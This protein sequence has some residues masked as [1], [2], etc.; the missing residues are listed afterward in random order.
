MTKVIS[1]DKILTTSQKEEIRKDYIENKMSLREIGDKYKI[2]SYEYLR[3]LLK[4]VM[5]TFSESGKIAHEK[6]PECF[7]HT[8][9]SKEKLRQA[10]LKYMEKNPDKTAWRLKNESYPEKLFTEFLQKYEYD[11]KYLIVK[12][13]SIFPYFIDFAFVNEKVAI[14]IDG[15][16]HLLPDRKAKDDKKDELLTSNGWKVIRFTENI[17]KTDWNT[18]KNTLDEI[19]ANNNQEVVHVGTFSKKQVEQ[20]T[21]ELENEKKSCEKTTKSKGIYKHKS[22][23]YVH[24]QRDENGHTEKEY[25][26]YY[27]NRKVKE[28][29]SAEQILE[30][31]NNGESLKGIGRMFNVSDNTIKKWCKTYNL[32]ISLEARG[33]RIYPRKC[34]VCGKLFKPNDKDQKICSKE[35][36]AIFNSKYPNKEEFIL[37]LKELKNKKIICK[38]YKICLK[39]CDNWL[40]YFKIPHTQKELTNYLKKI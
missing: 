15:S 33:K 39:T 28:R 19:F 9:I 3:K 1:Y 12:E 13:Y 34:V 26:C 36:K 25:Q 5:R 7:K 40:R 10:R 14:E 32:D 38:Y 20:I 8:D 31:L 11:K 22:T 30:W 37:K 23:P 29:P 6:H 17:V 24:V 2:K 27:N 16:Q 18:I 21:K 4:D 35:C